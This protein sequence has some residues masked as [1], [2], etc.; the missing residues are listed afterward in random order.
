MAD[1]F[2]AVYTLVTRD[3]NGRRRLDSLDVYG[4]TINGK[5]CGCAGR[6]ELVQGSDE[7]EAN[8]LVRH[9]EECYPN[10]KCT[11]IMED[12]VLWCYNCRFRVE[13]L[14]RNRK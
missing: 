7:M 10:C 2:E 3:T 12:G 8:P 14:I 11:P 13:E 6:V 5:V 9:P 4:H 1:K